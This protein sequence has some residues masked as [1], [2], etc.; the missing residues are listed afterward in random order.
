MMNSLERVRLSLGTAI[1]IGLSEGRLD[2]PP[3]TA[4]FMTFHEG[5]CTANCAFCPQARESTSKSDRLSRIA[6]PDFPLSEVMNQKQRLRTFQRACLQCLNY[7][8]V[9]DD[10]VEIVRQIRQV[11][12]GAISVCIH[13]VA[14][15]SMEN[16]REAG[17]TD[18]GIALDACT[19]GLFDK[20]KGRKRKTRYSWESHMKSL[21]A[22]LDVFGRGHVTTHLIIGLGETEAEAAKMVLQLY[23]MD[24]RV[25][26]FAFT[27]VEGTSLENEPPPSLSSYRRLQAIRYLASNR[28]ISEDDLRFNPDGRVHLSGSISGI[29]ES[30][31]SGEPFMTSGCPGCNRP[32]YNERPRG[33]MY[34]YPRPLTKEEIQEAI[35]E[36]K[37]L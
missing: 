22:A 26:L 37:L 15:A 21:N 36:T 20:V 18:I 28:L 1:K 32:Y 2:V 14:K 7:P 35:E 12:D 34:N 19:A 25:G 13:P 5:K 33:P 30:L 9:D 16:M 11:Y 3:T 8:N 31:S 4:F 24:I 29:R 27:S 6:W 23:S 17:A 10:A